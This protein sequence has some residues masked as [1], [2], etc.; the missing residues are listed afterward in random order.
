MRRHQPSEIMIH[1][2][3]PPTASANWTTPG[4][5]A[6]VRFSL[7]VFAHSSHKRVCLAAGIVNWTAASVHRY[8]KTETLKLNTIECLWGPLGA[9]TPVRV[10]LVQDPGFGEQ[11]SRKQ[12]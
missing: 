8:G 9:E 5:G 12:R 2:R 6:A 4:A 10:I 1:H 3:T 11:R 7:D